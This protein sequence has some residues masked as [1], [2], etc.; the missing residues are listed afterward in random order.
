MPIA[1]VWAFGIGM[2]CALLNWIAVARQDR[3]LVYVVKPATLAAFLVGAGLLAHSTGWGWAARWFLPALGF[4]L[5]GDVLLMLPTER[6]FLPGL[7]AFLVAQACYIV[8]LNPTLPPAASLALVVAILVMDIVVLRPII[9]GVRRSGAPELRAPVVV[10]GA[11]LSLT[12]FSG[13]ATWFRPAWQPAGRVL[14]S[15]GVTLFLASDLML[16]WTHF[17]RRSRTLNVLIMVTYHLAQLALA[18]VIGVAP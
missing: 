8:G 1:S 2:A 12:F 13:W 9:A 10:Y 15:I 16:A 7:L 17:V 6:W 11:I 18:G 4:S 3:G 14:V 5:L